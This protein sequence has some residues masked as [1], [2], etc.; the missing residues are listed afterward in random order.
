MDN[1]GLGFDITF[2][3]A[4][5]ASNICDVTITVVDNDGVAAGKPYALVLWLASDTNGTITTDAISGEI[6]A[7]ST[8][9]STLATLLSHYSSLLLTLPTGV[10]VVSITDTGKGP[11]HYLCATVPGSDRIAVSRAIV[12]ADYT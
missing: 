12:T 6:A 8:Y 7:K 10:L 1:Q 4:P 2:S 5:G 9:G 11:L 3:P